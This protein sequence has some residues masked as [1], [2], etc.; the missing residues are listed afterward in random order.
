LVGRLIVSITGLDIQSRFVIRRMSTLY[1]VN[2]VTRRMSNL[3]A[4]S[5]GFRVLTWSYRR[6]LTSP[7]GVAVGMAG[8]LETG[9]RGGLCVDLAKGSGDCCVCRD[10]RIQSKQ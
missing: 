9:W 10:C 8:E 2:V 6:S 7:C 3:Q 1:D 4:F 5:L